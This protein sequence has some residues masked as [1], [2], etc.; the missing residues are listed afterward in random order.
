M[1]LTWQSNTRLVTVCT[2]G[3]CALLGW[4]GWCCKL[5]YI[6]MGHD[7]A[8]TCNAGVCQ[9]PAFLAPSLQT[10]MHC[11]FRLASCGWWCLAHM[12]ARWCAVPGLFPSLPRHRESKHHR[13][14]PTLTRRHLHHPP[15]TMHRV[16]CSSP[17]T[18]QQHS[19]FH[20][21][22][23]QLN[24]HNASQKCGRRP[25]EGQHHH[26]NH[27]RHQLQCSAPHKW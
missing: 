7:A 16:L 27:G 9:A 21:Q 13:I 25:I 15:L 17:W 12:Y 2:A 24:V 3:W 18:R 4:C 6:L 26:H 20:S 11:R 23:H 19:V 10:Y 1:S 22:Q 14:M 8:H 5:P